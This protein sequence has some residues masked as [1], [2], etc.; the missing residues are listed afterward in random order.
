[1]TLVCQSWLLGDFFGSKTV[2]L[3]W[4]AP[5]HGET[6]RGGRK[7]EGEIERAKESQKEREG[8]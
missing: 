1:M 3:F 6:Q 2:S 8:D 7:R 4:P 5:S